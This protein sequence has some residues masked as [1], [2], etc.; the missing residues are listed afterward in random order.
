MHSELNQFGNCLLRIAIGAATCF[1]DVTVCMQD[2]TYVDAGTI[3]E[4][5]LPNRCCIKSSTMQVA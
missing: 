1:T 3:N 5:H 2:N 4:P